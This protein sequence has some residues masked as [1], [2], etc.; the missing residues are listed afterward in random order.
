MKKWTVHK[1][2]GYLCCIT[3]TEQTVIREFVIVLT[4]VAFASLY[5]P[6]FTSPFYLMCF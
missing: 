6:G 3:N 5:F 4:T 2:W 1:Y